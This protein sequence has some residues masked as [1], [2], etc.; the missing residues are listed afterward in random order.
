MLL[1]IDTSHFSPFVLLGEEGPARKLYE[2]LNIPVSVIPIRGFP[3]FP[4]YKWNNIE[5][6]KSWFC[7]L[8]NRKLDRYLKELKLD[9]VHI[10]DKTMLSAGLSAKKN[11]LPIV[12]HLRSSYNVTYSKIAALISKIVIKRCANRL[13]AISE[14]ELDGF[15]DE[16]NMK[17]IYNSVDFNKVKSALQHRGAI[18]KEMDLDGYVVI[19]TV[20]TAINEIRGT[21]DFIRAAAQIKNLL[22]ENKFK[23][24]IVSKIPLKDDKVPK[25]KA[26]DDFETAKALCEHLNIENDLIFMGFRADAMSIMA[27]M[28]VVVVC[29]RHG[30]LG[31][32]PFEA[33]ALGRPLVA[34]S[35]HTGK[36]QVVVDGQTGLIVSPNDPTQI[37]KATCR[38]LSDQA[39]RDYLSQN[40]KEYSFQ[41]FHPDK[42]AKLVERIYEEIL[43]ND[44]K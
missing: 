28:D 16:P 3:T 34:T 2:D 18:I 4:G 15:E 19:G 8:P 12:W 23:F 17:I 7:F 9:I 36:S 14:D 5:F 33:M 41:H 25:N 40:A 32:M 1:G 29:N 31:R 22:P 35:G 27:A 13:I 30:V 26:L 6:W 24:L 10:N 44:S 39:L 42:N 43:E 21:Y 20:S 11:G 37:A 38:L